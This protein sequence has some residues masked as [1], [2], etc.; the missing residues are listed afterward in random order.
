MYNT[1]HSENR[2][3]SSFSKADNRKGKKKKER[4]VQ[5]NNFLTWVKELQ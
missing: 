1:V 2:M 5:F 4:G 3:V